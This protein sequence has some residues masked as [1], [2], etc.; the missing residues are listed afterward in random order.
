MNNMR[1]DFKHLRDRVLRHVSRSHDVALVLSGGGARGL[2]HIG[3]IEA[4]EAHGYRITSVAG[5]SI[6]ALVGGI[7]AAGKLGELKS[8]V[9]SLDRK[10]VVKLMD[11]SP[12][13]DHIASGRRLMETLDTMIAGLR[14]E[15][16]PIS[17]CCSATDVVSGHEEVFR[18]G[19]LRRAIRASISVPGLFS[20]VCDGQHIFVDGSVHNALPL[21]H[22]ERKKGDL[23]VAVNVS[24][25]DAEPFTGYLKR[26]GEPAG[27]TD[28]SIWRRIPFL[29][30]E[31]SANYMNMML[32]VAKLS[33]QQNA[34]MAL[35]LTP[36]DICMEIP[37]G[38]YS[39]FDF[40][41]GKEIV[42]TGRQK[43]EEALR[44]WSKGG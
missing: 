18:S 31:F 3:A 10:S 21:D 15:T 34:Q 29:K 4:L 33:V 19:S 22:V 40:D 43:M 27:E 6:G 5:T 16:L 39:L 41:K 30:T 11:L 36:P 13:L 44:A 24:A 8:L 25:P 1:I 14:I 23:L 38:E 17:F 42:E 35:R 32:R 37:M 9:T 20:P 7:Y 12:G 28:R 26:Y 2:A